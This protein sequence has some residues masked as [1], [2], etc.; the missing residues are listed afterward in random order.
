MRAIYLKTSWLLRGPSYIGFGP[1][2][3]WLDLKGRY[4][5]GFRHLLFLVLALVICLLMFPI[6]QAFLYPFLFHFSPLMRRPWGHPQLTPPSCTSEVALGLWLEATPK[7]CST[8]S[9]RNPRS[10]FANPLTY[11]SIDI[12][13]DVLLRWWNFQWIPHRL[14][15]FLN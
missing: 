4:F 1:L 6:F 13:S 8:T 2:V 15:L 7:P 14:K 12:F 11:F 10:S 9:C 5:T 3:L